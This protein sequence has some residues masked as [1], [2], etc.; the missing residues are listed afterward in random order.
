MKRSPWFNA[1]TKPPVNGGGD[2]LYE[3]RCRSHPKVFGWSSPRKLWAIDIRHIA[4]KNC[5][6]RGLLRKEATK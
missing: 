4:C 6:W 3:H 5:E 2:A 1:Q